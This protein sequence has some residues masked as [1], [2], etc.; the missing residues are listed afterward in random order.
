MPY[1][2]LDADGHI[3]TAGAVMDINSNTI[4]TAIEPFISGRNKRKQEA[5]FEAAPLKLKP[6]DGDPSKGVIITKGGCPVCSIRI[7][8]IFTAYIYCAQAQ[9][10]LE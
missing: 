2:M 1:D 7:E 9:G 10:F 8:N 6:L 4:F 3:H 5:A